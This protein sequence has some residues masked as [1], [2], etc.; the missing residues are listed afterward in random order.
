MIRSKGVEGGLLQLI[1]PFG[2][3]VSGKV[4][5]RDSIGASRSHSDFGVRFIDPQ[6][7]LGLGRPPRQGPPLRVTTENG[8]EG[9][10]RSSSASI[11]A[12]S[13]GG[14]VRQVEDLVERHLQYAEFNFGGLPAQADPTP[15]A[16]TSSSPFYTLYLRRLLSGLPLVPH[17][18]FAHPAAGVIAVTSKHPNPIEAFRQLYTKQ[19]EGDIRLPQWIDND[20]LR[21]YVLVHEEESADI[22]KSN[23]IF[24]DMKRHFGLNCHMLRLKTQQCIPSDDDAVRLPTCEWVS[25]SEE[26]A[27]IQQR[28][29][30]SLTATLLAEDGGTSADQPCRSRRRYHRPD[31]LHPR[32]GRDCDPDVRARI[33]AASSSSA[34]GAQCGDLE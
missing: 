8:Q 11:R 13:L 14:D 4:T 10:P 22:A 21:Y 33:R 17:E 30:S 31:T 29:K 18:S 2:E 23:R 28:G 5:I 15:H 24:D 26:L 16:D 3:M 12:S 27:E 32:V 1:R 34:D 9:T 20:Y 25:A 19:Q 7:S 6:Q